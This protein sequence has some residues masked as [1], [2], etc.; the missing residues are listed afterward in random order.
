M[1]GLLVDAVLP[2]PV[3]EVHPEPL[4]VGA[5]LPGQPYIGEPGWCRD[6]MCRPVGE[7]SGTRRFS[8]VLRAATA[9]WTAA[10]LRRAG[11]RRTPASGVA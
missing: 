6:V 7:G 5:F 10:P 3:S 9:G 4:D 8:P 1:V 11:A 2:A